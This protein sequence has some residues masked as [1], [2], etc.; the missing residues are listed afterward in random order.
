MSLANVYIS[1]LWHFTIYIW[2]F[3]RNCL[4]PCICSQAQHKLALNLLLIFSSY[5]AP[6]QWIYTVLLCSVL[7][8]GQF[9]LT[10]IYKLSLPVVLCVYVTRYWVSMIR[11]WIKWNFHRSDFFFWFYLLLKPWFLAFPVP[12][13]SISLKKGAKMRNAPV[14][15]IGLRKKSM[16]KIPKKLVKTLLS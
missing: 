6:P 11:W 1:R 4:S 7:Q 13:S 16:I 2:N 5:C 15:G 14:P 9:S 3:F 12:K 8:D 10:I